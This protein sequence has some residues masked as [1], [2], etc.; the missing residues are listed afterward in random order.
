[1]IIK[2]IIKIKMKKVN[3][4]LIFKMKKIKKK[5]MNEFINKL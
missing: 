3:K 4:K 2:M 1:M 5:K